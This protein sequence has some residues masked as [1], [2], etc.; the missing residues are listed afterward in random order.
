VSSSQIDLPTRGELSAAISNAVVRVFHEY[1]GRGPNRARS[2]VSDDLISVVL[3]ETLTKGERHLLADGKSEIVLQS[4]DAYQ[5]AM[6]ADLIA[7]IEDLTSRRVRAFLSDNS[8]D[9]DIAVESF[10]LEPTTSNGQSD[11]SG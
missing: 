4:R 11:L 1:T 2:F 7:A 8:T 3:E 6:C 10:V 5:Q 9:P